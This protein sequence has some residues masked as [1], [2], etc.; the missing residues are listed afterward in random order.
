MESKVSR[1]L[2]ESLASEICEHIYGP[3]LERDFSKVFAY[4]NEVNQAH[5]LMLHKTSIVSP[6]VAKKLAAGLLQME[7]EGPSAVDL[8]AAKE[9]PYFNYE[10]KLMSLTG[11]DIGGRL[12]TARSRNDLSVTIDRIRARGA[13]LNMIQALGRVRSVALNR[14]ADCASVV[15][16]GYTHLQPA[17]PITFGFYLSGVAEALGRDMDRLQCALIRIDASPLGAGALAGTRFPIDRNVT[18]AGLGFTTLMPNTLDAVASRDFAWEAMSAMAIVALTWGRVA[19]DFH[20]WSTPEFGLVSFPDR[21]A[22]VSSIMPQKKNPVVLEYLRGKSSHIIGLLNT[23]LIAVKGTNF[24]HSGDSSRESMRNFWESAEETVRCLSLFELI[25]STVEPRVQNMLDH[26]RFDFSVATDLADGLVSE[27]GMSFRD[28]HHVVGGLVR[29]AMDAGKSSNELTSEML[30]RAAVDVIG[31]AVGWPE[32]KLRR[33]LDP[34][35]SVNARGSGGPAPSEVAIAVEKQRDHIKSILDSV[36]STKQRL[37]SARK[38]LKS[39][40]FA[41]ASR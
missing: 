41:L 31:A 36:E 18:A 7:A 8:D 30:D 12:H 3:R 33:F 32:E 24:T 11:R 26:V 5:L 35:M 19:Q 38:Q 21:V 6:D 27:S 23:A 9:D 17:Q 22:S 34:V 40:V 4:L 16:P 37:D 15:M 29:L 14:A 10:A 25:M 28:A 2:K 13:V 39:D 20:I 1:R